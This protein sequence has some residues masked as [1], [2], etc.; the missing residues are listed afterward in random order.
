MRAEESRGEEMS[1]S[2]IESV[3]REFV[4]AEDRYLA[5]RRA[6]VN[7]V[8][9]PGFGDLAR[10]DWHKVRQVGAEVQTKRVMQEY[11]VEKF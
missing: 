3:C 5:A 8:T 4:E 6:V 1:E 9:L 10:V 2:M 7:A 11:P